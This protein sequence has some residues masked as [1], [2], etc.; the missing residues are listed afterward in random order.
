VGASL[1]HIPLTTPS[2]L[3]YI[4]SLQD[5][6]LC[7][8]L[9]QKWNAFTGLMEEAACCV[10]NA[11]SVLESGRQSEYLMEVPFTVPI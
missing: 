9:L 1:S 2:S 10:V 8:E 11:S 5:G 6:F 4:R 3:R 7:L